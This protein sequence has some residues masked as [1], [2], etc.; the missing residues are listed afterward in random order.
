MKLLPAPRPALAA[1]MLPPCSSSSRR[2]HWQR[3]ADAAARL[4]GRRIAG[5]V[6]LEQPR[7]PVRLDADVVA[8]GELE[9]AAEGPHQHLDASALRREADGV[10]QQARDHLAQALG[11]ATEGTAERLQEGEQAQPPGV[12]RRLR[13]L[14]GGGHERRHVERPRVEANLVGEHLVGIEHL[15]EQLR[16]QRRIAGDRVEAARQRGRVGALELQRLRPAEHRAQRR[17]QRMRQAGDELVLLAQRPG[18]LGGR[19]R[20]GDFGGGD[21]AVAPG[22]ADPASGERHRLRE[23]REAPPVGQLDRVARFLGRRL[24]RFDPGGDRFGVAAAA[25]QATGEGRGR[26]RRQLRRRQAEEREKGEVARFGPAGLVGDE[27]GIGARVERRLQQRFGPGRRRGGRIGRVAHRCR[28]IAEVGGIMVALRGKPGREEPRGY[29][30]GTGAAGT[31]H[32][33]PEPTSKP[34]RNGAASAPK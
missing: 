6:A 3:Q 26:E 8:N 21:L 4:Y 20:R 28:P 31:F 34:G 5:V 1:V 13:R 17:A 25:C 14:D 10:G 12:G 22:P 32:A 30:A 23:A 9:L 33:N 19:R 16:L 18:R 24:Q 2:A 27:K 29:A 15:V 11:V 7:Q